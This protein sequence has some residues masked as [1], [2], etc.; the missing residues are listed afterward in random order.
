MKMNVHD[1]DRRLAEERIE[2][3][4]ACERIH[5]PCTN[6][7]G[8]RIA[9]LNEIDALST[10]LYACQN[11]NLSNPMMRQQMYKKVINLEQL[12]VEKR[13]EL[14]SM[15]QC[16]SKLCTNAHGTRLAMQNEIFNL[17]T[18][19]HACQK[20][21]LSNPWMRQQMNKKVLV[22]NQRLVAKRI[23]LASMCQCICTPCTDATVVRLTTLDETIT[24]LSTTRAQL[25]EKVLD[26]DR[27]LMEK[28][29][30][31]ASLCPYGNTTVS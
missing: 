6:T 8:A 11:A 3:A 4:Y 20:V 5:T 15:C 13:L 14:A 17:S 7:P 9:T 18:E 24:S 27:Q 26:L 19:I 21:N 10:E 16:V 28:K 31:R 30:E 25:R 2:P 29:R 23:E 1:L 22:L 12:L